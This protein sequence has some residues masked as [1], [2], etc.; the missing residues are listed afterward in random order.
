MPIYAVVLARGDGRLG[1][2]LRRSTSDCAGKEARTPVACT[3]R[4]MISS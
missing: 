1:P 4:P 3:V 2:D